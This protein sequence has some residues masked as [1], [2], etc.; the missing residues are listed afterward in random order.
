MEIT[1]RSQFKLNVEIQLVLLINLIACNLFILFRTRD[2]FI[3][4]CKIM[5]VVSQN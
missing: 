1:S 2:Y 5:R 3:I 4:R